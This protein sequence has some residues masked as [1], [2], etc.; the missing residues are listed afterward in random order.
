MKT[1]L[2]IIGSIIF[3]VL[4]VMLVSYL[5]SM[6]ILGSASRYM[7]QLSNGYAARIRKQ[8]PGKNCK[9]CGCEDCDEYA[10]DMLYRRNTVACPHCSKNDLDKIEKTVREFEKQLEDN[11]K[12]R[13]SL[14]FLKD[15]D[16]KI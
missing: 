14:R 1:W 4:F 3:T 10:A 2:I 11:K 12:P 8:L 9:K 7:N 16:R 15:E 5:S 6:F 13:K